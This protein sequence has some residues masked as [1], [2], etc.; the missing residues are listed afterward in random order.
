MRTLALSRFALSVCVAALLAGCSAA[1]PPIG[2]PGAMRLTAGTL[3]MDRARASKYRVLF[4]FGE[5]RVGH[6]G[7]YPTDP[8]LY[9]NGTF[10]GTTSAG[11]F[12]LKCRFC[13]YGVIFGLSPSG[14][15]KRLHQFT[16]GDG[17]YPAGGVIDVR[18]TL[19]GT[20]YSGGKYGYGTVFS[21]TPS[22]EYRVL[23]NFNFSDSSTGSAGPLGNLIDVNGKLYG[24]AISAG[25][26]DCGEVY[27]I[28]TQGKFHP[29]H[30]FSGPDGSSPAAGLLNV[31]GT[32][33][34]TTMSGGAYKRGTV[35]RITTKGAENVLF[36]FDGA[37]GGGPSAP[38]IAVDGRLYG[39]TQY[40]GSA[41]WGTVFSVTTDGKKERVL[42]SFSYE[43]D[44]ARPQAGL[45]DVNGTLYGTTAF[46]GIYNK[47][48]CKGTC[49]TIFSVTTSGEEHVVYDFA[50]TY[51][52]DGA[53][54][55][56][57]LIEVKGKLYGTTEFGGYSP[58]CGSYPCY[59]GTVFEF[60]LV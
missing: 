50:E 4:R 29:L 9:M 18:G 33:Y 8:L 23:Y 7:W 37:D 45:I 19:Y 17:A 11:G 16:G 38:L 20:T 55:A 57:N 3:P 24:T 58:N 25:T 41:S 34:G 43:N 31:N 15:Y 51:E 28:T 26:C 30:V 12:S 46:G 2:A 60:T 47:Y 5:S 59:D 54:P 10:Y 44:G 49:G 42:H 32:L 22:G 36:S 14:T 39:T 40:G 48:V 6:D 1:Q 13:G 52:N 53:T 21:V 35:F 56:A 27:S